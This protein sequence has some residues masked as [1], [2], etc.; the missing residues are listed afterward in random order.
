MAVVSL[1]ASEAGLIAAGLAPMWEQH[2]FEFN[3]Q[4]VGQKLTIAFRETCSA[5]V[6]AG[7]HDR[8]TIHFGPEPTVQDIREEAARRTGTS[9]DLVRFCSIRLLTRCLVCRRCGTGR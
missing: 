1:M 8:L 2:R 6:I 4:G 7:E 5:H 9:R 3:A